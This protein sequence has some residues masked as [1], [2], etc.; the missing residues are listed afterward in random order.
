MLIAE[1]RG[2][3]VSVTYFH[4]GFE[5]APSI[6]ATALTRTGTE[7]SAAGTLL[8]RTGGELEG[9]ITEINSFR[10]EAMPRGHMLLTR[11]RDLPGV[12]GKIGTVIGEKGINISNF[13]L[14]RRERGGEAMAVIETDTR[15]DQ[16]TIELLSRLE[17][18]IFVRP[19]EL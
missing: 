2:I 10:L 7:Q 8:G 17:E 4:G 12:I 1:E 19:I 6:R 14:G 13:H 5:K 3:G 16:Q 18:V 15:P 9:R 11:N